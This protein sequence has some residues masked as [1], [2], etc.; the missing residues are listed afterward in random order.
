MKNIVL[1]T[2][3]CI[4]F[5][6]L[7]C[8]DKMEEHYEVPGWL[9]GSTWDVLTDR[10]NYSIF[11]SG[12]EKVGYKPILEGKG[13]LTV[14]APND[15]VFTAYL[16]ENGYESINDI[17][18]DELTKLIGFHLLYYSYNKDKLINFRPEGDLITDEQKDKN[19]GLYY[20]FRTRSSNTPTEEIDRVTGKHRIVYHM[21]RFIPVFSYRFFD[22][23]KLDASA[24]YTYF[25]P[26]STWKGSDGFNVS[27]AAVKEY[28]IIADNGYIYD[29]DQ[30][31]KPLE[32]IYVE[33]EN[34][35]NYS[36]FYNLYNKY[37]TY[38]YDSRLSNDFATAL[39]T[40]SLF[41]HKHGVDLPA[42][43]MEWYSSNYTDLGDNASKAYSVF[44]PSNSALSEFFEEF[45]E[46]GGYES[47]DDVDEKVLKYMLDQYIY[48]KSIV[49]P[50]EIQKG[51]LKNDYDMTFD[52]D[53]S[54]V[55]DKAMCV[56]GTFYG[57][58]EIETPTLFASVIGPAFRDKDYNYFL[59]LLDGTGL[60]NSY[61]S[62]DAKY[63]LLVPSNAQIEQTGIYLKSYTTGNV[64]QEET[65]NGWSDI[66][67]SR[68]QRIT[69]I[70]TSL[71]NKEL[72][73]K[74]V[75][76]LPTQTGFNYWYVKDG[77]ITSSAE[78][79]KI[80]QPTNTIDPF[81]PFTEVK[82]GEKNWNNGKTYIYDS[83]E[84][85]VA[86]ESDGLEYQL[87]ITNDNRYVYYAF[88]KLMEKA[89]MITAMNTIQGLYASHFIAFIPTNNAIKNA[90]ATDKIPGI[91]GSFDDNGVLK[92]TVNDVLTLR[93]YLLSHF[94]SDMSNV[95]TTYPYPG[96]AMKN[97]EYVTSGQT[98]LKYTDAGNSISVQLENGNV[99]NVIS[100]YNFFPFAF[101]DGC[102]H[103]IDVVL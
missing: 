93:R 86:E 2:L 33:L 64:L 3:L 59:Y 8:T 12:V 30:V 71:S 23:K 53:P 76:I 84:L 92:A 97:G 11:L 35:E 94:I 88:A 44:A 25:Y 49:F 6:I 34:N 7:S 56:N 98:N 26:N 99:A 57:L 65:E 14:M 91:K 32:T 62:Q 1:L 80:L 96:S 28:G 63:I 21:D 38:V 82:N 10:G 40:D 17:S 103:L 54:K 68:K 87:A 90:L 5:S 74:D 13:V 66:S 58:N 45:W 67:T 18:S 70:H 51:L 16:K 42:I 101:N 47:L 48:K 73:N 95:I 60:I 50:E 20:K 52:F 27:N 89:G 41:V 78:F 46:K 22:T 69:N 43:A 79:N 15:E 37:S 55:E 85:F 72:S 9:R 102:F 36:M 100:D 75:Q 19:A 61:A 4:S 81:V 29:I 83:Q 24:N 31:L 77:K 39:G